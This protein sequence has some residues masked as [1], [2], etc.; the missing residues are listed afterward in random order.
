MIGFV[1]EEKGMN[2]IYF[3]F[4]KASDTE[5]PYTFPLYLCAIFKHCGLDVW[6]SRQVKI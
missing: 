2:V 3:A 1:H 5:S 4:S 6:M